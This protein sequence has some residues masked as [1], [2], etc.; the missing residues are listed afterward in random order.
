M[1]S[2]TITLSRTE[3]EALVDARDHA[4]TMREIAVG[5]AKILAS[6]TLSAKDTDAYLAARSPLKFWRKHRG[7]T[8]AGL[9]YCLGMH[10]SSISLAETGKRGLGIHAWVKLSKA[11][12]LPVED[13]L[14][15]E[16]EDDRKP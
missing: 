6:A 10:A 8:Q 2:H 15:L 9:A 11:L 14:P 13:L 7:F 16:D 1:P 12:N 5:G 3:Y 4:V